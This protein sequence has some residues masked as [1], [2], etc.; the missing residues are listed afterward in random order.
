M[1]SETTANSTKAV[2]DIKYK[3]TVWKHMYIRMPTR[4]KIPAF[5]WN[6]KLGYI[7]ENS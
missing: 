7:T 6:G 2:E 5:S 1:L 3:S 4:S